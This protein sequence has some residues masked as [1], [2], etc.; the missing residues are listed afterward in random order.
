MQSWQRIELS[1][2]SALSPSKSLPPPRR[3]PVQA[4]LL[5]HLGGCLYINNWIVLAVASQCNDHFHQCHKL[6]PD[7]PPCH[8]HDHAHDR[9]H[10]HGWQSSSPPSSRRDSADRHG[11]KAPATLNS[12]YI[13]NTFVGFSVNNFHPHPTKGGPAWL[14]GKTNEFVMNNEYWSFK[15]MELW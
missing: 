1:G 8:A 2:L 12:E 9:T 6:P 7:F 5:Q 11:E 4:S 14:G 13:R 3:S 15:Q 10:A